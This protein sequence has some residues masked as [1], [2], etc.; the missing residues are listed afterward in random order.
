MKWA[1]ISLQLFSDIFREL[2]G[3]DGSRRSRPVDVKEMY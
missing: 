2:K 1:K 3:K